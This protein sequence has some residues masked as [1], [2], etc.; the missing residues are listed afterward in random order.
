MAKDTNLNLRNTVF[1]QV[2]VRQHAPRGDFQGVIDDLKR[3]KALGVDV[4][5]LLPIHPIGKKARKGMVGSPYSISAYDRIDPSLGTLDDF[6]RLIDKA[7]TL[8]LKVM[9]DIVINHTSRDSDLVFEHPE[10]FYKDKNGHFANR[11][12][13]WS[14]I[15]DLDYNKRPVWDYFLDV[16]FDW[17]KLVDGFRC[18]VAPLIPIDFW[19][20]ARQRIQAIK[21][22]FIWLSE[23]VHL[24]FVKYLR[25][26]GYACA[27]DSEMYQAFDVLY[28]YDIFDFMSAYL[29]HGDPTR[30]LEEIERQE[31]VY[32]SNYVKLRSFENHD[33]P[34]LRSLVR[35]DR[36]FQNMLALNF[37][38]KGA[39]LI[40]AGME[41]GIAHKPDLFNNDPIP[42][43]FTHSF[44]PL[45]RRLAE[46]KKK[47]IFKDGTYHSRVV[48]GV[49]VLHY[50]LEHQ[51]LIGL[52]NLSGQQNV[53]VP[54]KDGRYM[55]RLTDHMV[56]VHEG[57][58][59]LSDGPIIIDTTKGRMP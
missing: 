32:P 30:W 16:L 56:T 14:D 59:S 10:W 20:E 41:H 17:A 23:S 34:R 19:L 18:D 27:S 55:N 39:P 12:G 11:V 24:S 33:Q 31:A 48:H 26:L 43:D 45:I 4:I 15:T 58:V 29:E 38:I 1:Y 35:D 54:L 53:D 22:N 21:P 49:A 5:Y 44:E 3:I 52:F 50:L 37:F 2:F 6:K 51:L 46:M 40:Y 8:G 42:W 28:D 9:M 25:D 36:H 57:R 13:D 7:H 47:P